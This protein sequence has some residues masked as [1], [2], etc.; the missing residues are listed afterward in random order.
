MCFACLHKQVAAM[1]LLVKAVHEHCRHVPSIC[2]LCKTA[3]VVQARLDAEDLRIEL[4][5]AALRKQ[6]KQAVRKAANLEVSLGEVVTDSCTHDL[7]SHHGPP[8]ASHWCMV[9]LLHKL[10]PVPASVS[11]NE[12]SGLVASCS[13]L[14]TSSSLGMFGTQRSTSDMH[15]A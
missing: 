15:D 14:V 10:Y 1:D 2:T 13:A 7:F 8:S 9:Q 5:V 4:S 12:Q 3:S 6:T 11:A